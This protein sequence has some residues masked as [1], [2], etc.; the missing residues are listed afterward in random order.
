[1]LWERY[2]FCRG[3]EVHELWDQIFENRETRMLYIAGRGFDVRAQHVMSELVENLQAPDRNIKRANLILLGFPNYR[4]DEGLIE[5]TNENERTLRETFSDIGSFENI[6]INSSIDN[7]DDI[8]AN[9]ALSIA[10]KDVLGKISDETDIILDISSLP[11]VVYLS[12][13]TNILNKLVQTKVVNS[14]DEHPLCKSKVNFHVLV[15]EDPNLDGLIKSEDP[16]NELILIPGFSSIMHLE[17]VKHWPLVWFPI[18]GE[19]RVNQLEKIMADAEIAEYAEICPV[20]PHPSRNPRR[21]DDLLVEFKGPLFDSRKTP[22]TNILHVHESNP[23][24]AYRQLLQAMRRYRKSMGILGG[25]RLVVS[26]LGSK[27]ITVGAALACFEMRPS[28]IEES[29]YG[30]AIPHAEPTRYHVSSSAVKNSNP[31]I[32]ALLLTGEAYSRL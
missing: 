15:G 10:V 9:A 32:S 3:N 4:L 24:E 31:D 26:P 7:E 17:S 12:L 2:V 5:L 21:A 8:S 20:I 19:N 30:V 27:L 16:S 18:L 28:N 13:I 29:N 22:T 11:R 14:S 25:C 1:M 23:F 6:N